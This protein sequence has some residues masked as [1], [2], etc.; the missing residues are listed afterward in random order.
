MSKYFG[1]ILWLIMFLVIT[2]LS[3][4]L[5]NKADTMSNLLGVLALAVFIMLSVDSKCLTNIKFN[6]KKH[7]HKDEQ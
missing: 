1:F 4:T 3:F 2:G 7:L 6:R 5:L